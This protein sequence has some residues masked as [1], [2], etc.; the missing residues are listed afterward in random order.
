MPFVR[1]SIA[2]IFAQFAFAG[3]VALDVDPLIV[4]AGTIT[5][6][7]Y[8]RAGGVGAPYSGV[9]KL[10]IDTNSGT[11]LCTGTVIGGTSILTAGHCLTAAGTGNVIANT[12]TAIL[13]DGISTQTLVSSNFVVHPTWNGDVGNTTDLAVLNFSSAFAS[14]VTRYTLYNT[15]NELGQTF[16]VAGYGKTGSNYGPAVE[17]TQGGVLRQGQNVW[18]RLNNQMFLGWTNDNLVMD[19]DNGTANNDAFGRIY[20]MFN[21]GLGLNE[22]TVAGGDSGGP[23]FLNGQLAGVTSFGFTLTANG[24]LIAPDCDGI[25]TNSTC[26]EFASMVRVSSNVAW[27]QAASVP[28]PSTFVLAAA[29]L[30]ALA[31]RARRRPD[32]RFV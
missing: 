11:F 14:W 21:T 17:G 24:G 23:S 16:N 4:A 30:A 29:A 10:F 32:Q 15:N 12:V 31:R 19:F 2:L 18:E 22:V 20:G 25:N 6:N 8:S 3:V 5:D 9:A 28:E 1:G 27:I 13:T 7:T 26:G